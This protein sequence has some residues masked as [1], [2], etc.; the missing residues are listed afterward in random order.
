ML[1]PTDWGGTP[2]KPGLAQYQVLS[3][4]PSTAAPQGDQWW[5]VLAAMVVGF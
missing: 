2:P 1:V 4:Q 3:E 5:K